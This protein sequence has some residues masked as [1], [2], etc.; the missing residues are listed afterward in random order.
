MTTTTNTLATLAIAGAITL[1]PMLALAD[2]NVNVTAST[3]GSSVNV[4]VNA[5][6]SADREQ[7]HKQKREERQHDR[8]SKQQNRG[9]HQIDVRINALQKLVDRINNTKGLTADQ[10]AS[11][12]ADLT[13]Q[14]S[15]LTALKTKIG[16]DTGTTTLTTDLKTIAPDYRTYRL[17]MPRTNIIA[18]ADRYLDTAGAMASSSAQLQARITAAQ[19]AGMNVSVAQSALADYNAKVA[20]A[21]T[22]AQAA[23][24]LV[25]KLNADNGDSAAQAA[26]AAALK[27]ART[28]L[29]AAQTDIRM[30]R[31]DLKKIM[32]SLKVRGNRE[33]M[34][35]TTTSST[36]ASTTHS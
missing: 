4:G 9:E 6:S 33:D 36:T 2:T 18:M 1:S 21:K 20:D 10:K 27:D 19:N 25:L 24:D 31:Q 12:T 11:L 17:V 14:I 16:S 15:A 29:H 23:I 32:R 22:Q 7:D 3:S 26:N 30:A 8:F 35:V 28:K 34:T 13:A 5:S